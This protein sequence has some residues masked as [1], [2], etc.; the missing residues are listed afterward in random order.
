MITIYHNPR[1]SKSRACHL[2][3]SDAKKDIEVINYM[4]TPFSEEKLREIID[5]L[6]FSPLDLVRKNEAIWK[7]KFKGKSLSDDQ[8]VQA[9]LEFP[10]LIERPIVVFEN[11]AIIAR[12]PEKV[13]DFIS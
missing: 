1:C 9:M 7:E 5:L 4:H 13:V 10:K 6:K 12:P 11:S 2:L 8:I 3:L